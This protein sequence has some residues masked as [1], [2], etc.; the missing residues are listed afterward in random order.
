LCLDLF[1]LKH[2][3]VFIPDEVRCL[4]VV[5]ILGHA[6]LEQTDDVS[7]VGVLSKTETSA[8]VHEFFELL[9]LVLAQFFNRNFLLLLFD[10]SIL[11]LLGSARKSLPWEGAF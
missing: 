6:R 9:W 1:L 10:V 3:S 8:V 2:E 4:Q 11:L 7:V 5:A